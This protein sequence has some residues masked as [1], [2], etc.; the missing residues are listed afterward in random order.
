[1]SGTPHKP[2]LP[3]ATAKRTSFGVFRK[4]SPNPVLPV[5]CLHI[6]SKLI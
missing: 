1:M 2:I 4:I 3:F 6:F 5:V